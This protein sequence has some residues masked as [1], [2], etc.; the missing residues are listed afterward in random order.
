MN[1]DVEVR[2]LKSE[3]N[4]Y[5]NVIGDSG[6]VGVWTY[7]FDKGSMFVRLARSGEGHIALL[8]F[9]SKDALIEFVETSVV[10]TIID[11]P[12]LPKEKPE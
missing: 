11:M 1:H 10:W 7:P 6:F 9:G 12:S 4:A 5:L 3:N 2:Q 8:A